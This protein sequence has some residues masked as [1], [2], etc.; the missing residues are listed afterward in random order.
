L[1]CN[2]D[3]TSPQTNSRQLQRELEPSDR[4]TREGPLMNLRV[5]VRFIRAFEKGALMIAQ[6]SR[7][8]LPPMSTAGIISAA[9]AT[10][11]AVSAPAPALAQYLTVVGGP[12]FTPG[13]GG[14]GGGEVSSLDGLGG[15]GHVNKVD[16]SRLLLGAVPFRWRIN[17]S[18][19]EIQWTELGILGNQ[20][21]VPGD[22]LNPGG[23]A[24]AMDG[25]GNVVG[26]VVDRDDLGNQRDRAVRWDAGG[27]TATELANLGTS[28]DGNTWGG[29]LDVNA[30][31][32]IVGFAEKYDASGLSQG[33]RALRWDAS[34]AMTELGTLDPNR[35]AGAYA[36]NGATAMNDAGTAI[37]WADKYDAAGV[38]KGQRAVRWDAGSTVPTELANLGTDP[39]GITDTAAAAINSAGVIVGTAKKFDAN[40]LGRTVPV[41]WDLSGAVT[42]L[43]TLQFPELPYNF[44]QTRFATHINDAGIVIGGLSP[45]GAVRWDASGA[46]TELKSPLGEPGPARASDINNAGIAVGT[47]N[48]PFAPTRALYWGL[49]AVPVD[50]N[51]LIDPASGWTLTSAHSINDAGWIGGEGS[52]DPDGPGRQTAINR[53]FLIR[54]PAAAVPEPAA[55][56]LAVLGLSIIATKLRSRSCQ[57]RDLGKRLPTAAATPPRGA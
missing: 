13:V 25:A 47:T 11:L 27:T 8:M 24:R 7:S 48:S 18:G 3:P 41:R 15:V 10:L 36:Y 40:G 56:A 46:A 43:E 54:V 37:G 21:P 9:L 32:T 2:A 30:A 5:A 44:G 49:D 31:G 19:T 28:P 29:A 42:E 20:V 53:L 33:W 52:F 16:A 50:L 12:T 55:G 4:I 57:R 45:G 23:Y 35:S 39:T 26:F 6:S 38:A 22:D 14:F 34:D 17:A 1:H 51:S